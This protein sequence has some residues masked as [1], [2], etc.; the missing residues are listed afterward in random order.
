MS[1]LTVQSVTRSALIL[2]LAAA[3]LTVASACSTTKSAEGQATIEQNKVTGNT[4]TLATASLDN[5]Y[6]GA[7]R[8]LNG[9][10]FKIEK[11]AKDSLKGVLTA[12]TA[13]NKTVS[14]D[15]T[16]KSDTITEIEVSAGPIEQSLAKTT[17][18]RIQSELR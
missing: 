1:S 4:S 15:L 2:A 16:R 18:E 13:D 8:A 12:R 11:Q 9:L 14:V 6:E 17:L 10:Q 7:I 5:A 3:A